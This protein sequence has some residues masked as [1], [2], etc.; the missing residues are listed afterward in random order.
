M[1]RQGAESWCRTH[2]WKWIRISRKIHERLLKVGRKGESFDSL[3]DRLV[4]EPKVGKE[5]RE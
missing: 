4:P 5:V 1:I 2:M 3:L